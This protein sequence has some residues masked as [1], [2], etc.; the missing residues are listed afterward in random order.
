MESNP[1]KSLAD[2][3]LRLGGTRQLVADDNNLTTRTWSKETPEAEAFWIKNINSLPEA[4]RREVLSFLPS[5]NA[6]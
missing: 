2:E 5:K 3:Y 6:V 4:Q 1:A